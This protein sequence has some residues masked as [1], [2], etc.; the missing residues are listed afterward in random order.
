MRTDR[1]WTVWC[2]ILCCVVW[3]GDSSGSGHTRIFDL[4][5]AVDMKIVDVDSRPGRSSLVIGRA[6]SDNQSTRIDL[7]FC[8]HCSG[9][10]VDQVNL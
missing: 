3:C 5:P 4:F 2:H 9:S 8:S 10:Q 1:Q 6:S 7:T